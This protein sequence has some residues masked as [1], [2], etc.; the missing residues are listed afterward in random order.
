MLISFDSLPYA[1]DW[2]EP[3]FLLQKN[4]HM[5]NL[6]R[7]SLSGILKVFVILIFSLGLLASKSYPVSFEKNSTSSHLDQ[8]SIFNVT[9]HDNIDDET[10]SHKHRHSEDGE[11]HEHSHDHT[12]VS[13]TSDIKLLSSCV[14]S[15]SKVP[16]ADFRWDFLVENLIPDP[17]P[18]KIYRPPISV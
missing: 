18:S 13:T 5:A 11:E 7:M 10:H 8:F 15:I 1:V 4:K 14:K 9:Q 12:K 6:I 16:E 3:L 17:H 2:E